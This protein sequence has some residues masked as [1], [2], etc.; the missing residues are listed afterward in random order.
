MIQIKKIFILLILAEVISLVAFFNPTVETA[1]FVLI[2]LAVFFISLW[3]LRYGVL[4][5]LAELFVGGMGYLFVLEQGGLHLSVRMGLFLILLAVFVYKAVKEHNIEFFKSKLFGPYVVLAAFLFLGLVLGY[6]YGNNPAYIF[7]DSNAFFFFGYVPV[8]FQAFKKQEDLKIIWPVFWAAIVWLAIKTLLVFFI[9]THG[10]VSII[11]GLYKWIRDT[12]VG[13]ITP[14]PGG[15]YRVFFQSQIYLVLGLILLTA[16]RIFSS[17]K[18]LRLAGSITVFSAVLLSFSRSLWLGL[19][20]ATFVLLVV[21]MIFLRAPILQ[22]GKTVGWLVA[23]ALGGLLL[24][25]IV[26][27]FPFPARTTFSFIDVLGSRISTSDAA[28]ATRWAELKPLWS[29]IQN[30]LFFGSGFG[31]TVTFKTQDPRILKTSPTGDYTTYAFE[32]GWLDV[33]LKIGLFGL[34]AYFNLLYQVVKMGVANFQFPISNFQTYGLLFSLFALII[35]H[36]FTPYLNHPLGLGW[37]ILVGLFLE[38]NRF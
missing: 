15:F 8:F 36:T 26:G 23:T 9:F 28:S 19:A 7:F 25:Y 20:A 27:Y 10:F 6:F 33:W 38:R 32:W 21:A 14:A 24:V 29:G 18:S 4:V 35:V 13:E 37:L 11:P 2:C 1:A 5:A 12:G 22:T 3:D 31:T 17:Q 30:H 34:V 16:E